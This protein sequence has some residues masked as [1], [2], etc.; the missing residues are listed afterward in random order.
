M[1]DTFKK[2]FG[3]Q[4]ENYTKFREPYPKE[5]FELLLT[6]IPKDATTILDIACGTGKSSEPLLTTGLKVSACD[7]DNLMI[8]EAKKQAEIKGLAIDYVVSDAEHLPY[9]DA[10]FDVV[11]IGTAFHFFVNDSAMSEIKRVLKPKGL[12]FVYWTLTTKDIP[13]EDEIPSSIYRKYNWMKIPSELRDLD[14][15]SNVFKKADLNEVSVKRI[16]IKFNTTVEERIGLQTTSGT[17][18]L[19]S[20]E[21][22]NKF[23]DEVKVVLTEKLGDR[24]FFTLE[25]E[26]QVCYGF[27]G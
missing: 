21:D 26:I 7:H 18:E 19:L 27:K 6:L 20:D 4:A 22:K 3:S 5:L 14:N 11:T 10:Y 1:I 8:V 25:E 12:L 16:P 17:Y 13:E 2:L 23:L 9:P 24:K 15:I